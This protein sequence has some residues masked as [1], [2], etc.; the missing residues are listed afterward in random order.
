V[1]ATYLQLLLV[2]AIA[3]L[4]TVA[5]CHALLY[6]RDPTAATGWL[7]VC[8]LFPVA[9]PTLY[10]LLGVNRI[11]VRAQRLGTG[12]GPVTEGESAA[13][14]VP[15]SFSQQARIS[16]A[17]TGLDITAGNAVSPLRDGEQAYP[18]MLDA[19][20]NA[21]QRVF[22]A[23]YIFESN[24]A[25]QDFADAMRRARERGVDVR[26]L[27]DGA[28]EWYSRP[29]IRH[30]LSQVGVRVARFLPP[31]LLPPRLLLNLRNHRKILV[32]DGRV[33]FTGGMNVGDRHYAT[34][35]GAKDIHFRLTGPVVSQIEA[36]F[37][38]DWT[39]TT[40][41]ETEPPPLA[42]DQNTGTAL[43]R[44]V[45]HGPNEELSRLTMILVG[46][47][48]AAQRRLVIV[49]PYFLPPRE[50]IA[51]LQAAAIRGTR[52]DIV[53]PEHNNLPFVHWATQNM[54]WEL[55]KW[56]VKVYYRGGAFAHSKL[57]LVDDE[58]A[59][60][61]SAN[62][63]PR[64]LRLNFELMVEVYDRDLTADLTAEVDTII[65]ASRRVQLADLDGRP[66]PIRLR[67]AFFWLFSPY[68]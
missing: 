60:V 21:E 6:K 19:I 57:F 24:S 41:D 62:M 18:A 38:Q 11:Q 20:E 29:R 42:T 30:R 61:G 67:D 65:E 66:L 17:V 56:G 39:Y 55:V 43:C 37:V 15:A 32:V 9:G 22:L 1:L 4:A 48:A 16:R 26:V 35:G 7:T 53:L 8:I 58:Y 33:G 50:L 52:V 10:F 28:G 34:K 64:S 47:A 5:G 12:H 23:T 68:L 51:A 2:I 45:V 40:G 13:I 49:T 25:G 59:Q 44:T 36:V 14:P 63:D 46:A 54:L 27:V 3:I 31:Q